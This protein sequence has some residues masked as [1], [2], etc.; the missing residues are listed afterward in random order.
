VARHVI[1]ALERA[2]RRTQAIGER[3]GPRA[4]PETRRFERADS[5]EN[6]ALFERP[7]RLPRDAELADQAPQLVAPGRRGPIVTALDGCEGRRV[8]DRQIV[9]QITERSLG[10]P[11]SDAA[12]AALVVRISSFPTLRT[13]RSDMHDDRPP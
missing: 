3:L 8:P 10:P 4:V 9:D 13:H 11:F 5:W 7:L 12:R 6:R 1:G 2:H